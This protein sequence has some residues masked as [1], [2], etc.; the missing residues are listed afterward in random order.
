M[1]R[2]IA[3]IF[4]NLVISLGAINLYS[5]TWKLI[6]N[7]EISGNRFMETGEIGNKTILK[8]MDSKGKGYSL[9]EL[10]NNNFN[11]ISTTEIELK[12]DI[13][14]Q[15]FSFEDYIYVATGK[16][17]ILKLD[18]KYNWKTL[19]LDDKY[20]QQDDK[21][22]R[23][24]KKVIDYDKKLYCLSEAQDVKFIDTNA[25]GA[26][27]IVLDAKYNE[28]I[29]IQ[30]ENLKLEY[31]IVSPSGE[32]FYD[33][34]SDGKSLWISS[35]KLLRYE[36]GEIKDSIDINKL[37]DFDDNAIMIK[38]DVDKDYI[39]LLK[40]RT[41]T[42]T[43]NIESF[44]VRY[45]KT[46]G[47]SEKFKFPD[48]TSY[49]DGKTLISPS[50]FTNMIIDNNVIYIS[51]DIGL[52]EYS[53]NELK[54]VDV[55]SDFLDEI[56]SVFLQY[57]RS[58]NVNIVGN[59]MYIS[60]NVGL[61][62]SD[63]FTSTTNINISKVDIGL[64]VYPNIITGS[65]NNITIESTEIKDINRIVIYNIEGTEVYEFSNLQ[66][67]IVGLMSLEVPNLPSGNYFIAVKTDIDN[68]ISPLI[69]QK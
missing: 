17:S 29:S 6:P 4:A 32:R 18:D 48:M 10:D 40:Q 7:A 9:V 15:L 3:I 31:S 14:S 65:T 61:I 63:D 27:A 12:I 67:S 59:T 39:Y 38:M 50:G 36:D 22:R 13:Q 33:I 51:S 54:Y 66:S 2:I 64:D 43:K 21:F 5:V 57:L 58:E 69:I 25:G 11:K 30:D 24:M 44:L 37:L 16:N 47:K 52:Y 62:Y 26:I 1:N 34:V 46:N 55:F 60:T 41:N 28:L 42:G 35:S 20:N 68:Y 56:P 49:A 23:I 45:D 8:L 53:N 19:E